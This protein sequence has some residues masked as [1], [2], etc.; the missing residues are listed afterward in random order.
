MPGRRRGVDHTGRPTRCDAQRCGKASAARWADASP[1]TRAREWSED[2]FAGSWGGPT[3]PRA[4][5]GARA[6]SD[7]R[8][9]TRLRGRNFTAARSADPV[10]RAVRVLREG[11]RL[12]SRHSR[13]QPRRAERVDRNAGPSRAELAP[14]RSLFA[15]SSS[16]RALRASVANWTR[17]RALSAEPAQGSVRL[18]ASSRAPRRSRGRPEAADRSFYLRSSAP[19]RQTSSRA[20]PQRSVED[21]G[22]D[23]GASVATGGLRRHDRRVIAAQP[24]RKDV[25]MPHVAQRELALRALPDAER[26]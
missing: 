14:H 5:G 13:R 22:P 4:A 16:P 9:E 24:P 18:S 1:P 25:A 15:S 3:R 11:R 12:R 6:Y 10:L 19:P 17:G 20:C 2:A 21:H 7:V 23:R 8:A 26:R